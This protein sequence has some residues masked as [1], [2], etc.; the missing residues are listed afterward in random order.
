M[1]HMKWIIT[2]LLSF[3]FSTVF[4]QY[5]KSA[6]EDCEVINFRSAVNNQQ[7]TIYIK[8]PQSYKDSIHKKYPVMYFLDAQVVF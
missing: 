2:G 7:Y 4:S 6:I 3:Y 8:L 5:P 1:H